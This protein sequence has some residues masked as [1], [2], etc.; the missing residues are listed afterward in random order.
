MTTTD[1]VSF[2]LTR[3]QALVIFEWLTELDEQ[4]EPNYGHPA[5]QRVV[6]QIQSQLEKLLSEPFASNYK[7]LLEEARNEVA[8]G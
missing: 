2:E 6:W 1:K 3:K 4:E 7:E 5:V 8:S